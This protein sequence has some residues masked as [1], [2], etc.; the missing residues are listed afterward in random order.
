MAPLC[1]NPGRIIFHLNSTLW[2]KFRHPGS[3]SK[4]RTSLIN[5][6]LKDWDSKTQRPIEKERRPDLCAIRR[7][8]D[9]IAAQTR[10]VYIEHHY[11]ALSKDEFKKQLDIRLGRVELPS[12]EKT[13]PFFKFIEQ[14]LNYQ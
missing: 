14:E 10:T 1:N 2:L 6:A 9:D 13:L 4:T 5:V 8:L 11:G 7:T 3:R 12:L